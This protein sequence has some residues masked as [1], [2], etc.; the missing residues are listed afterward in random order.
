[1][2][3]IRHDVNYNSCGGGSN[4]GSGGGDDNEHAKYNIWLN[5]NQS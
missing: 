3:L 1:M 2:S 4:D 5:I